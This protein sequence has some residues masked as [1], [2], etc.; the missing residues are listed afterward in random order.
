[1]RGVQLELEGLAREVRRLG[2]ASPDEVISGPELVER[3]MKTRVRIAP[4]LTTTAC[5]AFDGA[6]YR[7]VLREVADDSNFDCAHEL[8]H[9]AL[10]TIARY[11]G[12]DEERHA[13]A[14]AATILAPAA[15]V[16]AAIRQHGRDFGALR[17]LADVVQISQ[18]AA[19][20]R[21]GEILGDERAVLTKKNRNRIVR[22]R[23]GYG[24]AKAPLLS[25]LR[26]HRDVPGLAKTALEGGIDEGRVA[27]L[28]R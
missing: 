27:F 6:F 22:G 1:V 11:S 19:H 2:G 5:L 21:L 17:P 7:V 16:R 23:G 28:K 3:V 8:S 25:V 15:L 24:W 12:P 14:L 20:L 9:F 4:T 26:G 18:T 10:R 13:N